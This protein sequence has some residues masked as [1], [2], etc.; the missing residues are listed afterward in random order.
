MDYSLENTIWKDE[1]CLGNL[2]VDK[3]HKKIFSLAQKSLELQNEEDEEVKKNNLKNIIDELSF[4]VGTHYLIEQEFL[5]IKQYPYIKEHIQL[6]KQAI[7]AL[8]E[9]ISTLGTLSIQE[10]QEK[11][12]QLIEVH[13]LNHILKEDSK[14]IAWENSLDSYQKTFDWEK[15]FEIG[16][17]NFDNRNK[18]LFILAQEA[19]HDAPCC[20]SRDEKIRK[21]VNAIYE[22]MK[23]H[24][25]EEEAM[26]KE[27]NYPHLAKHLLRHRNIIK[28]MNRLVVQLP[29]SD[30]AYF[31]KQLA[32]L[33]EATFIYHVMD[34]DQ[35]FRKWIKEL[36]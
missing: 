28:Q 23:T 13:F 11:L 12:C 19:F 34:E 6:H 2:E 29:N 9:F 7:K 21:T 17:N 15:E 16:N 26:M 30:T 35:N 20:N 25:R 4:Y 27:C 14:V 22:Y 5:E 1:Y 24:F 10:V 18:E 36:Q 8:N 31:E 33:L 32:N 3:E